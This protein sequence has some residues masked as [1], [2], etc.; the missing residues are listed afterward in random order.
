MMQE[1]L[2]NYKALFSHEL[3]QATS[4]VLKESENSISKSFQQA[5]PFLLQSLLLTSSSAQDAIAETI[6]NSLSSDISLTT[7][8]NDVKSQNEDSLILNNGVKFLNK[9]INNHSEK[10]YQT[11]SAVS[12][13]QQNSS[14]VVL[15]IA[16]SL[17]PLFLKQHFANDPKPISSFFDALN[18]N[19]LAISN[20]LNPQFQEFYNKNNS[21][22]HQPNTMK[23]QQSSEGNQTKNKY[24]FPF[25]F[26]MLFLIGIFWWQKG[27]NH[28]QT[29]DPIETNT[30]TAIVAAED[31]AEITNES[32]S[33]EAN[34]E[35]MEDV[36][37]MVDSNGNWIVKKGEPTELKLESGV[38][39]QTYSN[40]L[41]EQLYHFIIEPSAVV[42][43][44]L[45]FNFDDLYF[46]SGKS[47]LVSGYVRQLDNVCEILKSYPKVKILIG[48]YTDNTGDSVANMKLS[49]ERAKKVYDLILQR[50]IDKSSFAEKPYDGYGSQYPIESNETAE[51]RAQNRRVAI[52][53]RAK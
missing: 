14:E 49:L 7:L 26:L 27:C 20:G 47:K 41:E 10:V 13:I 6:K 21:N 29:P 28:N 19:A 24:L 38:M 50:K 31:T 48:A 33:G 25:I 36:S 3:I 4:S 5:T 9:L 37:G 42:D 34:M 51:G 22:H 2:K 43:K 35:S 1:I 40:S 30:D 18:K 32:Q 11:L 17:L 8:I 12:G 53:V 44:N 52:S 46:V 23:E 15:I 16:S 39:I 45:W